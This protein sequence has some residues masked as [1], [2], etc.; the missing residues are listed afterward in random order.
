MKRGQ[1]DVWGV[2]VKNLGFAGMLFMD[3][4]VA[5]KICSRLPYYTLLASEVFLL[6]W[7]ETTLK[8]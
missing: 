2:W 6:F 8:K 1:E 7:K 4:K 3:L 5:S